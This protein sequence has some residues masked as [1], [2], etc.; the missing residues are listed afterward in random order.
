MWTSEQRGKKP[1]SEAPGELG[2]VTLGGDPA[3]VTMGG[4]R[5]WLPVFTPGGYCWRPTAG[6]KVLVLKAG[7][8]GESPC[9]LGMQ[10]QMEDLSPGEVRL[11][12]VE[13]S[14]RLGTGQVEVD[15]Q[16]VINGQTLE[17]IITQIVMEIVS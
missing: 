8:Q 9:I 2:R 1:V 6:D 17:E 7:G 12:G 4:E 15:G 16:M 13:C 3:A 11:K 14:L 10:Q 5:R